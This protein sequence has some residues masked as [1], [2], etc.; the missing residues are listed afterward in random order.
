M[1]L[2]LALDV[3]TTEK[4]MEVAKAVGDLINI[5]ELGTPF[6]FT[7]P[8]AAIGEFKDALPGVR[9]L[10]D[11]KIMDGGSPIARMAFDAGADITTVSAR[12]WDGT[13]AEVIREA[14]AKGAQVLVDMMGVPDNEMARR[15]REIEALGADYICVHRAVS[16]KGAGSPERPL[17]TLR[18]TVGGAKIAVAG[19]ITLKT[20]EKIV[21]HRPDL[22]I[23]GGAITNAADP[24][25]V[26]VAMRGIMEGAT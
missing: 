11:Y 3:I 5:L 26:A 20:L 17:R 14:R 23:V 4:G 24:R 15:G 2:Q 9:I 22:V 10:A 1:E 12:T 13:I 7:Y 19:G 25:A 6:A 16:V 8:L 21:P 18:D